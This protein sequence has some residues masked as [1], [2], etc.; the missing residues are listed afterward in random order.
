[1]ALAAY[2]EEDGLVWSV[3]GEALK[4]VGVQCPSVGECQ[5]RKKGVGE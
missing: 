3:G 4:P 1:M 5:G 2:V